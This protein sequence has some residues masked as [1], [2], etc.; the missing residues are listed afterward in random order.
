MNIDKGTLNALTRQLTSDLASGSDIDAAARADAED[1]LTR[2]LSLLPDAVAASRDEF[3]R[4]H[5]EIDEID[6]PDELSYP[7]DLSG[8]GYLDD[9]DNPTSLRCWTIQRAEVWER[10]QRTG[11]HSATWATVRADRRAAFALP[12]TALALDHLLESAGTAP[13][14]AF[15]SR[16]SGEPASQPLNLW[17]CDAACGNGVPALNCHR[18][19]V[20]PGHVALEVVTPISEV[21]GLSWRRWDL[22]LRGGY[23]PADALDGA[24]FARLLTDEEARTPARAWSWSRRVNAR[25]SM[26]RCLTTSPTLPGMVDDDAHLDSGFWRNQVVLPSLVLADVSDV[27]T[28][29]STHPDRWWAAAIA[30]NP[31]VAETERHY[32]LPVDQ[33]HLPGTADEAA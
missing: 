12:A 31:G 22:A 33:L 32:R 23:V 20:P 9:V 26:L 28:A 17:V 5:G 30:G 21:V 8:Q 27:L 2:M 13:V 3:A 1:E 11:E 10:L 18:T 15:T 6:L 7:V 25:A 4:A 29:P 14:W 16:V 24:R 19:H